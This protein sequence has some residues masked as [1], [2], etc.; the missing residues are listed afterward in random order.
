[1]AGAQIEIGLK[2]FRR[3]AAL[4]AAHALNGMSG[5]NVEMLKRNE[6]LANAL[7]ARAAEKTAKSIGTESGA[8]AGARRQQSTGRLVRATA[9]TSRPGGSDGNT[10]VG[11]LSFGVGNP[12]WLDQA[13]EK[14]GRYWRSFEFGTE[15][16]VGTQITILPKNSKG[17]PTRGRTDAQDPG[18]R[19]VRVSS[20]PRKNKAPLFVTHPIRPHS[21]YQNLMSSGEAFEMLVPLAKEYYRQTMRGVLR[22]R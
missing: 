16:F 18:L 22:G 4:R 1:M 13:T 12:T 5:V 7:A 21:V 2:G 20:F 10:F 3:D 14:E 11:A 15:M 19:T 6:K 9:K 8:W 17:R